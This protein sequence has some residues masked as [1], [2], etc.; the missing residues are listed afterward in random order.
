MSF[1]IVYSKNYGYYKDILWLFIRFGIDIYPVKWH[2]NGILKVVKGK[3]RLNCKSNFQLCRVN[4]EP[5]KS[6]LQFCNNSSGK[7][8]IIDNKQNLILQN[9][10]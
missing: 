4:F 6:K 3:E 8:R 5:R 9:G 7:Q 2:Y 1:I 10:T